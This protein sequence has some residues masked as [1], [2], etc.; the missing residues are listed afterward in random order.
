ME[1]KKIDFKD[2]VERQHYEREQKE[3]K[4]WLAFPDDKIGFVDIKLNTK[5]KYRRGAVNNTKIH[6]DSHLMRTIKEGNNM[7]AI[8]W[9]NLKLKEDEAA[10]RGT[11][12][13]SMLGIIDDTPHNRGG[14]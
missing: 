3:R 4:E 10:A 12:I 1:D 6:E 14:A 2:D 7:E 8:N 13:K 9:S 11:Q 5:G